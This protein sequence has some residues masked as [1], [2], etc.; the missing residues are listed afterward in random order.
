MLSSKSLFLSISSVLEGGSENP[1]FTLRLAVYLSVSA[2]S[3]EW[4]SSLSRRLEVLKEPEKIHFFSK[5][6]LFGFLF[7]LPKLERRL[8][9]RSGKSFQTKKEYSTC[10]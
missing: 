10:L 8:V 2:L 5:N 3:S 4:A 1:L 6:S 9:D 7:R